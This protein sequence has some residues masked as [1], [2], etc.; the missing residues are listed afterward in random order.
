MAPVDANATVN[1]LQ[2]AATAQIGGP[3]APGQPQAV[4]AQLGNLQND[5]T[6]RQYDAGGQSYFNVLQMLTVT[7]GAVSTTR[8]QESGDTAV[9]GQRSSDGGEIRTAGREGGGNAAT[10]G[11]GLFTPAAYMSRTGQRGSGS[12]DGSGGEN[13]SGGQSSAPVTSVEALLQ[14]MKAQQLA[15]TQRQSSLARPLTPDELLLREPSAEDDV[16]SFDELMQTLTHHLA[17]FLANGAINS[18]VKATSALNLLEEVPNANNFGPANLVVLA[19]LLDKAL[20]QG[21]LTANTQ[22]QTQQWQALVNATSMLTA[23]IQRRGKD[24][25]DPQMMMTLASV[26]PGLIGMVQRAPAGLT[27]EM[28]DRLR[29]TISSLAGRLALSAMNSD[30]HASSQNQVDT[31]AERDA[32][33]GAPA[34]R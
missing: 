13:N 14:L 23:A 1:A 21:M 33:S 22:M 3:D 9:T 11:L 4:L 24:A 25:L 27:Q 12:G 20:V 19:K 31:T 30:G 32:G 28:R 6:T 2:N 17:E 10:T 15:Q 34:S 29:Q 8:A 16:H 7:D 18:G 5:S 26:L